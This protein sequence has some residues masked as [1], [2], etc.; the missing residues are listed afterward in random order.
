MRIKILSLVTNRFLNFAVYIIAMQF[1][2]FEN[3]KC[4][5][6]HKP[7]YVPNLSSLLLYAFK[8]MILAAKKSYCQGSKKSIPFTRGTV[9]QPLLDI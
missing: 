7:K 1:E 8:T 3:K 2:Q 6:N 9:S 5:K 4:V